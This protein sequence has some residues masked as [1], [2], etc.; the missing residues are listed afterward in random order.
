MYQGGLELNAESNNFDAIHPAEAVRRQR[1]AVSAWWW[2]IPPVAVIK[3]RREGA[4]QRREF[5]DTLTPHQVA[6]L[7]SFS[8]KATGWFI[9]AAG[10]FFIAVKETWH[11]CHLNHWP[12]WVYAPIVVIPLGLSVLYTALQV[13]ETKT[14]L[15][16]TA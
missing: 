5:M 10:A 11:L 4:R 13:R 14:V 8:N 2:L 1:F 6:T 12:G 16:T 3:R 9:V 15:A 7:V